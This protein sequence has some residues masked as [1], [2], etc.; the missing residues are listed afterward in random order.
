MHGTIQS[1]SSQ[2]EWETPKGNT[3]LAR[4][5]ITLNML[6][7]TYSLQLDPAASKKN[8]MCDK[9]FTKEQDGLSKEWKVNTIFNPPFAES[10]LNDDGTQKMRIK[11][12]IEEPV[13]RNVIGKWV[14][15]AVEQSLKHRTIV[16]GILPVYTGS[17]WFQRFIKDIVYVNYLPGRIRYTAPDGKTGSPNFDSMLVF[18]DARN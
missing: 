8:T 7:K 1:D 13:F 15:K 12:G 14:K 16:I 9:Y 5:D 4:S 10:V 11:N 18:W 17:D 3:P 6:K 2:N